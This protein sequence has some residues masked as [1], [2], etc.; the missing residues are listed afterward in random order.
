M[1]DPV[2]KPRL[3]ATQENTLSPNIIFLKTQRCLTLGVSPLNVAPPSPRSTSPLSL[4]V[5]IAEPFSPS[6]KDTPDL[7]TA[8]VRA[9]EFFLDNDAGGLSPVI[10]GQAGGSCPCWQG[11]QHTHWPTQMCLYP[12]AVQE[13][14]PPSLWKPPDVISP[15]EVKEVSLPPVPRPWLCGSAFHTPGPLLATEP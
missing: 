6:T 10:L 1:T 13:P 4:L 11:A 5:L 14:G 12:K 8:K 3:S 2:I 7:A 9:S 15:S